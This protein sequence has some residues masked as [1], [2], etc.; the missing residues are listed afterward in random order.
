MISEAQRT[1]MLMFG[2]E[3]RSTLRAHP[4]SANPTN[5]KSNRLITHHP[6]TKKATGS[7]DDQISQPRVPHP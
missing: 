3:P 5:K 2:N 4:I 7:T 1:G 6:P